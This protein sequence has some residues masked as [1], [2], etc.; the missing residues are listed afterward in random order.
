MLMMVGAEGTNH[1]QLNAL[2]AAVQ[3]TATAQ[4]NTPY[5]TKQPL[6]RKMPYCKR[7][8]LRLSLRC[9]IYGATYTDRGA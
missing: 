4:S 9:G 1:K 7:M 6:L 5:S 2:A 8:C 3:L